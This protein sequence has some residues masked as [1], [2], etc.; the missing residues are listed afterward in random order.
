MTLEIIIN[1]AL[2]AVTGAVCSKTFYDIGKGRGR[3][4]GYHDRGVD[5]AYRRARADKA[6]AKSKGQHEL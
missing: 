3:L 1:I 5:D 6:E 2:V 4:E